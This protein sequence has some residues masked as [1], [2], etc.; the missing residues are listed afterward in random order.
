MHD[1]D[2]IRWISGAEVVRVYGAAA[3]KALLD[4]GVADTVMA[5]LHLSNGAIAQVE[6][7]WAV[8]YGVPAMLDARLEVIGTQGA[9]YIDM[10]PQGLALFSGHKFSHPDTIYADEKL[11]LLKDL[12][13]HFRQYVSGQ[14]EAVATLADGIAALRIAVAV[15]ESAQSGRPVDLG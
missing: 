6:Q 14:A 2:A 5:T 4:L 13:L 15:D 10:T 3:S 1:F 11:H 8:P 9:A 7:S 12:Y